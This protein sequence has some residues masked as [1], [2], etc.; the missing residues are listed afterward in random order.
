M[1]DVK[2]CADKIIANVEKV[3][4]GKHAPVQMTVL[5]LL[6]Q[7]HLLIEDV[8]GVGK[9]ML[10]RAIAKSIGSSFSRIQFTPDM[11]PSD[12]TGVSVFNQKT[13]EFEFREG[14]VFAQIVLTDEINRATPK[15][16]SAL[17]EAMGEHQITVD[18]TTYILSRPFLVLAT[19]NP[20]EYEGTFP[21]P[22]AQLDRFMLRINLGYPAKTDEVSI[23]EAQRV[24][25]PVEEI[26]EAVTVEELLGAQEN[27]RIALESDTKIMPQ[28]LR[29]HYREEMGKQLAAKLYKEGLEEFTRKRLR[30]SFEHWQECLKIHPDDTDCM[31]G[32]NELEKE[33]ENILSEAKILENRGDQHVFDLWEKVLTI[34]R[35]ESLAYKKAQL[36]LK[37]YE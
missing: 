36:K 32:L 33:A 2:H 16:Q 8:P 15:T 13:R 25:H 18:G 11:L 31:R 20:I 34:T 12:V 22:E 10:A 14:P 1:E 6:C 29:S 3:I 24:V 23:L 4:F 19:Q 26:S 30:K 17:L 27:F 5:A 28:G 9:T 7:G 37:E 21:L 35:P